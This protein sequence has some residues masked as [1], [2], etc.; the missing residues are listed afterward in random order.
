MSRVTWR[1]LTLAGFGCHARPVRLELGEGLNVLVAPNEAG[2]STLVAG[3]EAVLFGL[4]NSSD[5]A[6]FGTARFRPRAGA[7]RLEGTVEF[8]A[9]GRNYRVW[10]DFHTNR[11]SLQEKLDDAWRELAGGEHNPQARRRNTRYEEALAGL[12]GMSDRA[13]FEATFCLA[14]PLPEAEAL[15]QD[16]QRLVSGAGGTYGQAL[17]ALE[18]DL[19]GIT[20]FGGDLGV[21]NNGR[22]DARLEERQNELANLEAAVSGARERVDGLEAARREA[23]EAENLLQE[24]REEQRQ[25]QEALNAW[26][27]WRACRQRYRAALERQRALEEARRQATGLSLRLAEGRR[28]LRRRFPELSGVA[29][30]DRA[31]L[32]R[33]VAE[34]Q[35]AL[36]EICRRQEAAREK[37]AELRRLYGDLEGLPPGAAEAAMA[38]PAAVRRLARAEAA[39]RRGRRRRSVWGAVAGALLGVLLLLALGPAGAAG[40]PVLAAAGWWLGGRVGGA[41]TAEWQEAGRELERLDGQLGPWAGAD[42]AA[43]GALLQRL[44]DRERAY[45]EYEE[46]LAQLPAAG[47]EEEARR[48]LAEAAARREAWQREE[49]ALREAERELQGLLR[50]QQAATLEE[51]EGRALDAGNQA[52]AAWRDWEDLGRRYPVLPPPGDAAGAEETYRT[53]TSRLQELGE[54]EREAERRVEAA[55]RR[56]VELEGSA[57]LN[58]A[59]AEERLRELREETSA[60]EQEARALA[61]AWR[62]LQEA[63]REYHA[64][65]RQRLGDAAGAYFRS[66][67]GRPGRRLE[68]DGAFQVMLTEDGQPLHPRQLSRGA[69]DQLFL[70]LRLA[71]ADLL[72]D[73]LRLPL[74]LDDPFLNCDAERLERLRQALDRLAGER[75]VWL[76]SQREDFL[77]WGRPV[78]LLH[79]ER[80]QAAGGG[81]QVLAE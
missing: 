44:R 42:E 13:L 51:L 35:A 31:R 16:V 58:L 29:E 59:Q 41:G 43:L 73:G 8:T 72:A 54:K 63:A 15:G 2:K 81:P 48:S 25:Q 79:E 60:L 74:I 61:L 10:R 76:L 26:T 78:E 33:A 21:G 39:A 53:L 20:R 14:Q 12:L 50:G 22:K 27:E 69:R 38:R 18:K 23:R 32:E 17:Q 80:P 56:Q 70:S 52:L 64:T 47:A 30:E 66:F 68:L 24:L 49:A 45:R 37:E 4:P 28:E 55:R 19:K 34:R 75:Q 46:L 6:E 5:P 9:D 7:E 57:P 67:T 62:L 3:L 77:S 71:V 36:G 40:I 65:H 1:R 11:V